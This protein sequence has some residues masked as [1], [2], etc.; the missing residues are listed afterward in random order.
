MKNQKL[1]K[2]EKEILDAFEKGTLNHVENFSEKEKQYKS[3]AQ[4]TL[5]KPK[6]INIRLSERD[7]QRLKA[8]AAEKGLPYQTFISSLLHQ[9]TSKKRQLRKV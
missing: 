3:Y 4:R 6:N 7:L 9:Y 1:T 5:S 8:I 2:E